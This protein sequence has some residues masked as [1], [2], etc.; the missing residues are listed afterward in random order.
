MSETM[1]HG[2]L[3]IEMW[4]ILGRVLLWNH[5]QSYIETIL[6][7]LKICNLKYLISVTYC[8]FLHS[9]LSL[10]STFDLPSLIKAV[11]TAGK[12]RHSMLS[13][14]SA[15]CVWLS[16]ATQ[17]GEILLQSEQMWRTSIDVNLL[18]C[19]YRMAECEVTVN[20]E[21]LWQQSQLTSRLYDSR[22]LK[23]FCILFNFKNGIDNKL[24]LSLKWWLSTFIS[25]GCL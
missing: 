8:A 11:C 24:F 10:W 19:N 1:G 25:A 9:V 13:L 21:T 2:L 20:I 5:I 23:I 15:L 4:V 16:Y 14:Q 7:W 3:Q 22:V 12:P 18:P 17:L 6:S